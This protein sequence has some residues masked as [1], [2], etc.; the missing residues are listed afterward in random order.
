MILKLFSLTINFKI[1]SNGKYNHGP[2][3]IQLKVCFIFNKEF[4]LLTL[5]LLL[6]CGLTKKICLKTPRMIYP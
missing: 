3:F 5:E 4:C 1:S 2:L 6:S